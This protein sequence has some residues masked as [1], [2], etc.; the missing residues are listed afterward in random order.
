MKVP[1]VVFGITDP[2]MW[3][4]KGRTKRRDKRRNEERGKKEKRWERR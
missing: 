4:K 1:R 2:S 3:W